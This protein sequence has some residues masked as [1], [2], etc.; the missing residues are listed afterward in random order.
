MSKSLPGWMH[1]NNV[2][3]GVSALFGVAGA[4]VALAL[5]VRPMAPLIGWDVGALTYVAWTL[6][7]TYR[8][9]AADTARLATREDPDRVAFDLA[10]LAASVV[11][12]V[13][14]GV[15]LI[16]SGKASGSDQ[17]ALVVTS[18]VSVVL[19]WLLVHTVYGLVYARLYYDEPKGGIDFNS[20][21]DPDYRDFAYLAFTI[22]MTYQVSDTAISDR[23]IR[24]VAL[25]QAA[26]A[27]LFGTVILATTINLVASLAR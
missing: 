8:L 25:H 3:V 9:N 11:S 16:E 26:V 5:R 12:L 19:S 10:M 2:R 17:T 6:G 20:E 1:S 14:V 21:D 13:A 15:T 22:G 18:V 27:Y 24:R 7:T 23:R 4:L